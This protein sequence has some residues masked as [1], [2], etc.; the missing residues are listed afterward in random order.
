MI[1][2]PEVA[3]YLLEFIGIHYRNEEVEELYKKNGGIKTKGS[4]GFDLVLCEDVE[5]TAH[6]PFIIADL[7]IIVKMPDTMYAM[8]Q[9]RSSTYKKL[10]VIQPNSPGIIDSDYCGE[11][12]YWR[13]PL[14][15][16]PSEHFHPVEGRS[17]TWMKIPKGTAIAQVTFQYKVP[18]RV[19]SYDPTDIRSRD[20]FGSTDKD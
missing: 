1:V 20:G 10:R 11:N 13:M 2:Q 19:Y 5:L 12:D 3:R 9:P 7:G 16:T 15:L 18:Y 4:A 14:L 6:Q 17:E 8:V